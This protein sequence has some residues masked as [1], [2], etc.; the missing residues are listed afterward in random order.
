MIEIGKYN[1]LKVEKFERHGIYLYCEDGERILLPGRYVPDGLRVDDEIE[2]FVYND[3]EDRPIATT[4]KP[5]IELYNF[6]VLRAKSVS[7]HGAF[8]DWGLMKDLMIPFSEQNKEI[9][10]GRSY[11][12]YLKLD[13]A[14]QRLVGSTK[15]TKYLVTEPVTVGVGEEVDLIAWT[16]SDL[17]V[18]VIINETHLGLVFTSDI[19]QD[20]KLGEELKGYIKFIRP[21]NKIDVRLQKDAY[22]NIEPNAVKI[23][24]RLERND[25]FLDL[26]DKSDPVLITEMLGMSKKAFKSAVGSLYKARRI[27]ISDNGLHLVDTK[28]LPENQPKETKFKTQETKK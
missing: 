4:E 2:V 7:K 17:G 11:L 8:M 24:K 15:L 5:Y 19:H 10:E 20:I 6:A 22:L 23:L 27:T 25:G 26:N 3:S 28:D 16:K 9:E 18:K 12:V 14:T 13:E 21:D 1:T